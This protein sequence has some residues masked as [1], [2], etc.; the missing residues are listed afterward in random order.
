MQK[1]YVHSILKL[2]KNVSEAPHKLKKD[3]ENATI[4]ENAT[5]DVDDDACRRIALIFRH[6]KFVEVEKDSGGSIESLQPPD[7]SLVYVFGHI[8]DLSTDKLYTRAQLLQIKAHR[9]DRRGVSG[10]MHVGADAIIVKNI[11]VE[12]GEADNGMDMCYYA[13]SM[14]GGASLFYSYVNHLPIRVFRSSGGKSRYCPKRTKGMSSS[15]YQY[16][17]LFVVTQVWSNTTKANGTLMDEG[18]CPGKAVLFAMMR[19]S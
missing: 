11:N 2:K 5:I 15:V 7:C 6:G 4:E 13:N 18:G 17:G 16:G 14:K 9:S 1:H 12:K 8:P 10:N 19:V 3:L